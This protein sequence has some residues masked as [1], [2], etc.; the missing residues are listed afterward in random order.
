GLW[1]P[2]TDQGGSLD[3]VLSA[4]DVAST[5]IAEDSV[6]VGIPIDD[7]P[8]SDKMFDMIVGRTP[9]TSFI[10]QVMESRS[11][12]E[13]SQQTETKENTQGERNEQVYTSEDYDRDVK[14][15]KYEEQQTANVQFED[16]NKG[17]VKCKNSKNLIE[18]S[19]E[20]FSINST[21]SAY[22]GSVPFGNDEFSRSVSI[23]STMSN[24]INE[25]APDYDKL[26][27]NI[28]VSKNLSVS[29]IGLT[30]DNHQQHF[31]S[32]VSEELI[33]E[34]PSPDEAEKLNY[35]VLSNQQPSAEVKAY[36][37]PLLTRITTEEGL[38]SQNYQCA[39][40]GTYIGMVYG[41]PRVC[42]YDSKYYCCECHQGELAVIPSKLL[43]N[44]DLCQYPVCG[45][46][47]K[48][49]S[50]VYHQPLIDVRKANPKIYS[51]IDDMAEMQI[52]R[53][54]LLYI[55]AYLFT[56]RSGVGEKL[57][58]KLWPR[59]HLYEHVHLYST[60]DLE[61]VAGGQ[62]VSLVRSAVAWGRDHITQCVI[63]APRGFICEMCDDCTVLYPFQLGITNTCPDCY[64]VSHAVCARG[65]QECPRCVRRKARREN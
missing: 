63:C 27:S 17:N 30:F 54:Q 65:K 25:S 19:P 52:L 56:C 61:S 10:S 2:S 23:E 50:S 34:S 5:F 59:E 15:N 41:K 11:A 12:Q 20:D 44:W 7:T 49:L 39:N 16:E 43:H 31:T 21:S 22:I 38:D 47:A 33:E 62:L 3:P 55:Q 48:W 42:K 18:I 9:E 14:A 51:H 60:Y 35:E 53:T 40:C 8:L 57:K 32:V 29:N 6:N 37:L 45:N 28:D 13:E 1:A 4:T 36:L 26:F 24:S 64:A 46:N 58:K